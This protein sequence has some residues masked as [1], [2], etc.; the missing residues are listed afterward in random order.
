MNMN[1]SAEVQGMPDLIVE[2]QWRFP[3]IALFLV[4]LVTLALY[5]ETA[6]AMVSI[7][8]RSET[9][10]HGFLI[11]PISLWLIWRNRHAYVGLVPHPDFRA[12]P[13][14]AI[15]GFMWL[16]SEMA[17]VSVVSQFALVTMLVL[18]V[19]GILGLPIT[20]KMIFPLL[21]LFFAV[22][23]GEFTLPVLMEWTAKMTILG[24][25][26]SGVPV[27]QEG[28]R[29]VIPS[30]N[31]SV[32]E[33]CSGVR[34]LIA[35]LV[36]GTLYAYLNYYS[37]KRRLIFIGASF[38]VPIIANWI[39]A[40]MIV[41]LG[42]L[43]GNKIATGVD[44][45]I[46]G[47]IFFGV[48]I[49]ILFWIGARWREDEI[50]EE[51]GGVNGALRAIEAQGIHRLAAMFSVIAV[52]ALWPL[53]EWI[54]DHGDANRVEIRTIEPVSGW[55]SEPGGLADL[56]PRFENASASVKDTFSKNGQKVGV[57]IAYYRHQGGDRR[58]ISSTNVLVENKDY[59]W[60]RIAEGIRESTVDGQPL[61]LKTTE[62]QG[63]VSSR[64]LVWQWYWIHG[65]MTSSDIMVKFYTA[66]YRIF[67][68]G[69]DSAVIFAYT[70]MESAGDAEGLLQDFV[71]TQGASISRAL[72]RTQ[73]G[74]E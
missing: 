70:P 30:G 58:M 4:I 27:Y 28:L 5:R 65:R 37:L 54:L 43:S 10:A 15:A 69:D 33:A 8:E 14:I 1:E 2:K 16:L 71:E 73:K 45:L 19:P 24:L 35:S 11:A 61:T 72:E 56:T 67:G 68:Q 42:H 59:H 34:Y 50:P 17:A 32:V 60:T 38:V 31:W 12:L 66:F 44:H 13:F 9:F 23:F 25:R 55:E 3:L 53:A 41:M 74:G 22:P 64:L 26:W 18:I 39:R 52:L 36:V 40:Y 57:F 29:F 48:V 63:R 62:L 7:W 51:G 49:M 6:W 46:Y 20:R 47:W 21:F